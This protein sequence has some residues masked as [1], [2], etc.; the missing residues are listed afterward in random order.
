MEDKE[1]TA[2]C[3]KTSSTQPGYRKRVM[4]RVNEESHTQEP[5]ARLAGEYTNLFQSLV[6]NASNEHFAVEEFFMYRGS[7]NWA[8][9]VVTD[10]SN[11][12]FFLN[13]KHDLHITAN[14]DN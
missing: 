4:R 10:S 8:K 2:E 9:N 14:L 1:A 7:K 13:D 12:Q 3:R 5:V 6:F 11:F